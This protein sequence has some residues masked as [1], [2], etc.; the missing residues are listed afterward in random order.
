MG[1]S[2]RNYAKDLGVFGVVLLTGGLAS[3]AALAA[4]QLGIDTKLPPKAWGVMAVLFLLLG[5]V[6]AYHK[7]R[8]RVEEL[9]AAI[10]NRHWRADRAIDEMSRADVSICGMNRRILFVK[11][12]MLEARCPDRITVLHLALFCFGNIADAENDC[13]M[14]LRAEFEALGLIVPTA[15]PAHTTS[16]VLRLRATTDFDWWKKTDLAIEVIARIKER[17]AMPPGPLKLEPY[18]AGVYAGADPSTQK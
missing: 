9:E 7:L 10:A 4:D 18:D 6:V 11:A 2:F 13:A 17:E 15:P 3:L 12:F 5:P 14:K 8:K 16:E 1:S